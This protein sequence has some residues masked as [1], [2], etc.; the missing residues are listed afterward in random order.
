MWP[1]DVNINSANVTQ[2]GAARRVKILFFL[3]CW[4]CMGSFFETRD[5]SGYCDW[6]QSNA[7]KR[8]AVRNKLFQLSFRGTFRLDIGL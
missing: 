4:L 3:G 2:P 7:E 8:G 5:S 1:Y 6:P